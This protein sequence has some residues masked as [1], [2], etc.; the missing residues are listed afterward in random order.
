MNNF[1]AGLYRMPL[2]NLGTPMRV[3]GAGLA[4]R[5]V[6]RGIGTLGVP[7]RLAASPEITLLSMH[8]ASLQ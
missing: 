7:A 3:A 2:G 4:H 5:Y 1:V 8:E 6:T